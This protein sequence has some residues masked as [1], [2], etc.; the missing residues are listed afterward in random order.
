MLD[1]KI[2]SSHPMNLRIPLKMR[3]AQVTRAVILSRISKPL[4]L[5]WMQTAH[6]S[7]F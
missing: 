3:M 2:N 6:T 4:C 7:L 1:R 5:S